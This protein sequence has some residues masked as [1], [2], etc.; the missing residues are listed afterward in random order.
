MVLLRDVV[1]QAQADW[2]ALLRDAPPAVQATVQQRLAGATMLG[3]IASR[4][5]VG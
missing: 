4:S 5:A 3:Q 1:K 2:P